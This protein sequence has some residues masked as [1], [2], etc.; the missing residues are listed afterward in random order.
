M[1]CRVGITTDPDRRKKE[2]EQEFP[3]L[4]HWTVLSWHYT[5]TDAQQAEGAA[6]ERYGCEAHHGGGGDEHDRWA[7]YFFNY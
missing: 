4:S 1:A 6:A 3:E 2:W 7:V 5:K